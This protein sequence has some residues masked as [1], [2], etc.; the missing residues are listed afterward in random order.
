MLI[1]ARIYN[2]SHAFRHPSASRKASSC[3]CRDVGNSKDPSSNRN[4]SL[5][6]ENTIKSVPIT[7]TMPARAGMLATPGMQAKP[8]MP[9]TAGVPTEKGTILTSRKPILAA[10][11]TTKATEIILATARMPTS[12]RMLQQRSQ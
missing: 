8:G 11:K 2:K 5:S 6:K 3:S 1:Y 9:A 4:A 7:V 10:A 12:C